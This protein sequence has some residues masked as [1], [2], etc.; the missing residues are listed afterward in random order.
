[1]IRKCKKLR[2]GWAIRAEHGPDRGTYLCIYEQDL[3]M[4]MPSEKIIF[5]DRDLA[6]EQIRDM[7]R[8]QR[9]GKQWR[10]FKHLRLVKLFRWIPA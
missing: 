2:L 4:G 9:A 8:S 7:R 10:S 1:M 6:V 3:R 5:R